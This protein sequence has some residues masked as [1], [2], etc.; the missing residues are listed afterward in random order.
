MSMLE[1]ITKID[2]ISID[3]ETNEVVLNI[4]D[5]LDWT[6]EKKHIQLL[7]EKINNYIKFIQ[8]KEIEQVCPEAMGKK[9]K[10]FI[11]A[12]FSP[13]SAAMKWLAVTTDLLAKSEISFDHS[14]LKKLK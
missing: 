5:H 8:S 10:F 2:A 14:Y 12:K 6:D 4:F 3:K 7:Q 13:N 9:V 1:D 11:Q